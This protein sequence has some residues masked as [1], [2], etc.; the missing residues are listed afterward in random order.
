MV[1]CLSGGDGLT[2]VADHQTPIQ[3]LLYLYPGMSIAGTF[4]PR[5]QL[6]CTPSKP[7]GVVPGYC[8]PVFEAEDASQ[9][10][11]LGW[12]TVGT[13]LLRCRDTEAGVETRQE[14]FQYQVSHFNRTGSGQAQ[15]CHQGI[16]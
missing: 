13:P 4:Q 2:L 10:Q 9:I 3:P 16:L 11:P 15:L 5:Q 6:K 14:V 1:R 12:P 7:Y 8:T